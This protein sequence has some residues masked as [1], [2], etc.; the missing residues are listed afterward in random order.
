MSHGDMRQSDEMTCLV[1]HKTYSRAS[2]ASQI[3]RFSLLPCLQRQLVQLRHALFFFFFR[4][5]RL[6]NYFEQL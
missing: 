6:F 2:N 1:S 4:F 3:L 5:V